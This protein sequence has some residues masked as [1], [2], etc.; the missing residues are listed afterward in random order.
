MII[1]LCILIV[2]AFIAGGIYGKSAAAIALAEERKALSAA[3]ASLNLL[4]TSLMAKASTGHP[5]AEI[6]S[7]LKASAA[8]Y[9]ATPA[10]EIAAKLKAIREQ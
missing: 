5:D 3:R 1:V 6:A 9:A 2:F 8:A 7:K 4:G 10:A